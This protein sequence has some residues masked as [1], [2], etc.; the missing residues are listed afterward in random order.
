MKV[1]Q[2]TGAPG[3]DGADGKDGIQGPQGE[4][5]KDGVDGAPGQDGTDGVDGKDGADGEPG[6]GIVSVEKLFAV[7]NNP[8]NYPD[9]GWTIIENVSTSPTN[10]YMWCKETTIFTSGEPTVIYYIVAIEGEPG[11]NGTGG[12]APIIYPAGVWSA[13]KEYIAASDK[14]PYV[15]YAVDEKYYIL[16][17]KELIIGEG[18]NNIW[19]GIEYAPGKTYE[20][21][22]IWL[23]IDSFEAIYSD[24]GLF[25]Q[26]LVGK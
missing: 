26:A 3:K 2:A 13:D 16:N 11:A 25:N 12:D 14:V 5:G 1:G 24:I 17:S 8:S 23:P 4:P 18:E 19:K 7:N 20:G 15:F 21:E 9:E 22:P 6:R 10:R